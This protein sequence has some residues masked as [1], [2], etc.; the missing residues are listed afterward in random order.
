VFDRPMVDALVDMSPQWL[1]PNIELIGNNTVAP[2]EINHAFIEAYMVGLNHEMARE[3]SWR[4]IS[5]DRRA[6][7]FRRFWQR[8]GDM[9]PLA[10]SPLASALGSHAT[11]RAKLVLVV[12]GDLL[13]Q[14]PHTLVRA[15]RAKWDET[16]GHARKLAEADPELVRE[17]V[18]AATIE[19]DLAV[20]GFELSVDEARGD[21]EDPGWFL[22]FEQPPAEPS[23][24]RDDG[25]VGMTSREPSSVAVHAAELLPS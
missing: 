2:V 11:Q 12:R 16:D 24:A 6:T 25:G 14:Y 7:Y 8:E 15:R 13:A 22:V 18:L 4:G 21:D 20:V 19:G 1:L 5:S 10:S 9:P 3:L 23:F 17:P